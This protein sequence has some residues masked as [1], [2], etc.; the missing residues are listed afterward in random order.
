MTFVSR[1]ATVSSQRRHITE[2]LHFAKRSLRGGGK[3]TTEIKG[4]FLA[5]IAIGLQLARDLMKHFMIGVDDLFHWQNDEGAVK[6]R[7]TLL[8]YSSY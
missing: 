5:A 2:E 8:S 4:I 1:N 6:H 3:I 7:Q